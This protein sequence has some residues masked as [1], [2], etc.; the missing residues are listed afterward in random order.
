MLKFHEKLRECPLGV[1][2]CDDCQHCP[3]DPTSSNWF[4]LGGAHKPKEVANAEWEAHYSAQKKEA[5]VK[6]KA[7]EAFQTRAP[8][9]TPEMKQAMALLMGMT[10]MQRGLL[11]CWFCPGC[12]RYM[13]P[14]DYCHCRNDE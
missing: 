3:A 4:L 9:A 7:E 6:R 2:L 1:P 11:L 12:R 10:E 8:E 14:G 13:G 5:E